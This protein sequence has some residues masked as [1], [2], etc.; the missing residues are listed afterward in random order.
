MTALVLA[1]Y[2]V[3]IAV[4]FSYAAKLFASQF[5]KHL[6]IGRSFVRNNTKRADGGCGGLVQDPALAFAVAKHEVVRW[7]PSNAEF[8][9]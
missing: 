9:N 8:M 6:S 4:F 2:Q 1:A 3:W 5:L 7:S